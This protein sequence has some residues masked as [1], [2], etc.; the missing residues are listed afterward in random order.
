MT[1]QATLAIKP[2]LIAQ[3][4]LLSL[5]IPIIKH[6]NKYRQGPETDLKV[7]IAPKKW[8]GAY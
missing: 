1:K 3:P 6:R 2:N 7:I 5:H 4:S 8:G